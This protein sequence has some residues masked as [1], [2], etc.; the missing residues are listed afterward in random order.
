MPESGINCFLIYE[1]FIVYKLHLLLNSTYISVTILFFTNI[2]IICLNYECTVLSEIKCF[3]F[4]SELWDGLSIR[5][6]C[7]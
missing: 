2:L 4:I 5:H 6:D 7:N 3:I 1:I